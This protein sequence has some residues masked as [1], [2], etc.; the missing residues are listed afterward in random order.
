[1]VISSSRAKAVISLVKDFGLSGFLRVMSGIAFL[2]VARNI[3]ASDYFVLH[4]MLI[5]ITAGIAAGAVIPGLAKVQNEPEKK[6]AYLLT[7]FKLSLA[8]I[9][10]YLIVGVFLHAHE[11]LPQALLGAISSACLSLSLICSQ[12]LICE[13]KKEIGLLLVSV[14][15][16]CTIAW[17]ICNQ[18]RIDEHV[19]LR[20]WCVGFLLE[21]AIIA[22]AAGLGK[23]LKGKKHLNKQQTHQIFGAGL[24]AGAGLL[25][26]VLDMQLMRMAGPSSLALYAYGTKVLSAVSTV[27]TTVFA[28]W[29]TG[30]VLYGMTSLRRQSTKI[31]LAGTAVLGS[32]GLTMIWFIPHFILKNPSEAQQA[33]YLGLMA[34]PYFI[35]TTMASFYSRIAMT[36]QAMQKLTQV[37]LLCFAA[38][39]AL[40]IPLF[41]SYEL[42]GVV[43]GMTLVALGHIAYLV[44]VVHD[45]KINGELRGSLNQD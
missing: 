26:V 15:S 23:A 3:G 1:M 25:G 6:N 42:Q 41:Y 16:F 5:T 43:A 10:A 19:A 20:A 2:L 12:S 27:L 38:K 35:L 8:C 9:P 18:G 39:A 22:K 45:M 28:I 11:N 13:G 32:A 34:T 31:A 33:V 29:A 40:E 30:Q 44:K 14:A 36:K 4:Q 7:G 17:L 24:I 21:C 37:S